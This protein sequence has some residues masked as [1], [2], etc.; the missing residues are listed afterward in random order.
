MVQARQVNSES[1]AWVAPSRRCPWAVALCPCPRRRQAWSTWGRAAAIPHPA[2]DSGEGLWG[3]PTLKLAARGAHEGL[4]LGALV[5]NDLNVVS[6]GAQG[7][8]SQGIRSH[9]PFSS[10]ANTEVCPTDTCFN[11][12]LGGGGCGTSS[13]LRGDGLRW[14]LEAPH[15]SPRCPQHTWP[16]LQ[17]AVKWVQPTSVPRPRRPHW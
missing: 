16:F 1:Q 7:T 8:S 14:D 11:L 4:M 17:L 13:R 12:C 3:R 6:L 9:L 15:L 5:G 10:K 2:C